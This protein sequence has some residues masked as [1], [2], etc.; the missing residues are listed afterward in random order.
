MNA[1]NAD[2]FFNLERDLQRSLRPVLPDPTFVNQL[3]VRLANPGP[4][5]MAP[6]TA[7]LGLMLAAV[8]LVAGLVLLWVVRLVQRQMK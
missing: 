8:G 5:I 1:P 2:L 6:K 7:G 3:Q 4:T